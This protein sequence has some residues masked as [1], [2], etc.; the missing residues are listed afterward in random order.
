MQTFKITQ[1]ITKTNEVL[2]IILIAYIN[3]LIQILPLLQM[4]GA[5]LL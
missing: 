5:P 3:N 4:R 1:V 2:L